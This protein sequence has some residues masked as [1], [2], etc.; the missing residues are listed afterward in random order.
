MQ[1]YARICFAFTY[2]AMPADAYLLNGYAWNGYVW[3]RVLNGYVLLHVL[4]SHTLPFLLMHSFWTDTYWMDTDWE[5]MCRMM[6]L[7]MTVVQKSCIQILNLGFHN[8]HI[9][10]IFSF[11]VMWRHARKSRK[12]QARRKV[13]ARLAQV[14]PCTIMIYFNIFANHVR[15]FLDV[16]SWLVIARSA[17][18]MSRTSGFRICQSSKS[19][20]EKLS[21]ISCASCAQAPRKQKMHLGEIRKGD[22]EQMIPSLERLLTK[23]QRNLPT[24]RRRKGWQRI[25]LK[26]RQRKA[27]SDVVSRSSSSTSSSDSLTEKSPRKCTVAGKLKP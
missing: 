16:A 3:T 23:Y 27:R 5:D 1:W 7:D 10:M 21:C 14:F 26:E 24:Q 17:F 2:T 12:T 15:R 13:S 8:R 9:Y 11:S 22:P 20:T 6:L 19:K 4:H 25:A 18:C